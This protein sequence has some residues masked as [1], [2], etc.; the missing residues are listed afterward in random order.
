MSWLSYLLFALS[1]AGPIMPSRVRRTNTVLICDKIWWK[2]NS[3]CGR[4]ISNTW[5]I[6]Q[7]RLATIAITLTNENPVC[8]MHMF[9]SKRIWKGNARQNVAGLIF[10][11][12]LIWSTMGF[13]VRLIRLPWPFSVIVNWTWSQSAF[14]CVTVTSTSQLCRLLATAFTIPTTICSSPGRSE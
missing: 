3:I 2:S 1:S 13:C 8:V 5:S 7:F 10:G 14:V 4:T 12:R 6:L 11:S 9:V